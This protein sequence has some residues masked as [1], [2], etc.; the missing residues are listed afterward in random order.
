MGLLSCHKHPSPPSPRNPANN[1]QDFEEEKF[2]WWCI[3]KHL[4][5]YE[6][7]SNFKVEG[8]ASDLPNKTSKLTNLMQ[9]NS[10]FEAIKI[11]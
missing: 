10:K 3:S 9:K 6:Y 11:C 5:P 4:N 1:S 2:N 7:V 8:S